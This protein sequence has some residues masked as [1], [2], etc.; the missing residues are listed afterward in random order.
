MRAFIGLLLLAMPAAAAEK[1]QDRH[2]AMVAQARDTTV[3]TF[4]ERWAP[5]RG[6][7][8]RQQLGHEM[9][10]PPPPPPPLRAPPAMAAAPMPVV[11]AAPVRER[12]VRTVRVTIRKPDRETCIR[13]GLRTV[14]SGNSWRCR[15]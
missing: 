11:E 10:S 5:V 12:S 2:P 6:L 4:E 3:H 1:I 13:H 15:R 7:L 9:L 8:Y 14:W